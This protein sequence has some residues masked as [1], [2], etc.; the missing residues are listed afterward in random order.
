[1]L[2]RTEPTSSSSIRQQTVQPG[3]VPQQYVNLQ[4]HLCCKWH[5]LWIIGV[6]CN[7]NRGVFRCE[8]A[9]VNR[10]RR[11]CG[12]CSLVSSLHRMSVWWRWW[13]WWWGRVRARMRLC[14]WCHRCGLLFEMLL[15]SHEWGAGPLNLTQTSDT[16]A[17]SW[18]CDR[19]VQWHSRINCWNTAITTL[20]NCTSGGLGQRIFQKGL[21]LERSLEAR[22]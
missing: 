5:K 2:A 12:V 11:V 7:V 9:I 15:W 22:A 8:C 14:M 20:R 6:C 16:Q 18:G 21:R 10:M 13:W 4:L 17:R 1:M 19:E 3:V